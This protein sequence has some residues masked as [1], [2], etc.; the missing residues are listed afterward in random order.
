MR[1]YTLTI[2]IAVIISA[3]SKKTAEVVETMVDKPAMESPLAW[4]SAAPEPGPARKINLGDYSTSQLDN[5]LK[6]IVVENH[7]LPRASFQL[8]LENLPILE[9]DQAGFVDIAGSL[10]A[11]GTTSR[12]KADIDAAIDYIGASFSTFGSGMFG[13]S[14][15]KHRDKL[16]EIMTDVLYN[17]SF[18]Q[19]EFDK[20]KKQ[21]ISGI[22]SN[23]ADPNSMAAN[24]ASVLRNT[25]DHPYGEIATEESVGNIDLENCKKYYNEFFKPNNATLTIVGDVTPAE[26]KAIAEKY[27]GEWKKGSVRDIS[28]EI[29]QR[30]DGTK[31]AF[32]NKDGAVQS[33]IRVTYPVELK[34]GAPDAIPASVMNSILGGG[35][36]SGRLMQ[37]LR[38]DKAYT[39]G[40]RSNL[41]S[42]RLIG[43]FNAFTSVRNEVTDSSI[44]EIIYEMNRLV[45]EL[46]DEEDLKLVKNSMTGSFARSLESPQTIARF[47]NNIQRFNLPS[48]YY[49]TYLEKLNAVSVADIQRMAEKYITP[50]NAYVVVVGS[51]DEVAEKLTRFDSDGEIDYYDAFGN[52][53]DN[54]QSTVPSDLT[55]ETVI[56]DYLAAI[57]GKKKLMEVKSLEQH[58]NMDLMGQTANVS[59]FKKGSD[60]FA[61]SV[62]AMGMV[63]QD[64]KFDGKSLSSAQMGQPANVVTE[65]PEFDQMKSQAE[66]FPQLKYGESNTIKLLGSEKVNGEDCYKISV[67]D[68]SGN[69]S[70]EYYTVSKNL[71][72][73]MVSTVAAGPQTITTTIDLSDYKEVDGILFPHKLTTTGAMPAPIVMEST[74]IKVNQDIPDATFMI[75]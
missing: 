30:P 3:C 67:V 22:Q 50:E 17:P 55:A 24:V 68:K 31:V 21:T 60:K 7:K 57:G 52:L 9:K 46:V 8:S 59:M 26:G 54:S 1:I 40:A 39:Y 12:S 33:V 74:T 20:A 6:V 18:S 75:K 42:N 58:Y 61:M 64:Q 4:R 13:S 49:E 73:R 44:H 51:K 15:T 62:N 72:S 56:E 66:I 16:L 23:R 37:N 45:T 19:D 69:K 71:L 5:G 10:L 27:F 32:V 38:E 2:L 63:V 25:K 53:L 65:G 34:P 48:D 36:F 43:S 47:A 28:Y 41:S 14:L 29:P 70:T 35:I 11:T